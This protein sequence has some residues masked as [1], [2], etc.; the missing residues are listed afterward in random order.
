MHNQGAVADCMQKS[1]KRWKQL[2][3]EGQY[4]LQMAVPELHSTA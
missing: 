2:K 1:S 3:R 4:I